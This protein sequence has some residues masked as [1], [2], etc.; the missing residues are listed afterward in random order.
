VPDHEAALALG[1]PPTGHVFAGLPYVI[2][3]YRFPI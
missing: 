3:G 2:S 1:F